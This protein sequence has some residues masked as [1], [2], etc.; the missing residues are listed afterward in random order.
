MSR[1]SR[2]WMLC[3]IISR[4]ASLFVMTNVTFLIWPEKI[5]KQ[6]SVSS[7][8]EAATSAKIVRLRHR[9]A[10]EENGFV[11]ALQHHIP[12]QSAIA[13]FFRNER[14]ASPR[15]NQFEREVFGVARFVRK[16]N[17]RHQAAQ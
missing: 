5:E 15:F 8:E 2:R 14:M 3:A 7:Q 6:Y 12:C 10:I 9:S 4:N 16:I 11:R 1:G 17:T 13:Q